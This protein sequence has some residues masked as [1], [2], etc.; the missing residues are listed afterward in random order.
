MLSGRSHRPNKTSDEALAELELQ[1]GQQFDPEVIEVLMRVVL[2]KDLTLSA[3]Q[4][5]RVLVA[6]SDVEFLNLLKLRLLNAGFEVQTLTNV[7]EVA[8]QLLDDPPSV[9]LAG[10]SS[11]DERAFDLL[12][13]LRG[14]D[15]LRHVPIAFIGDNPDRILRVRAMRHGVDDFLTK[16]DDLEEVVSRVE[17]ILIREASRRTPRASQR[18][19][20]ITGQLDT[21]PLPDIIQMLNMGMK[22]ALVSIYSDDQAGQIWF[23]EGAAVHAEA[24]DSRGAEAIYQMLRW[25]GGDFAIEHG[26]VTGGSTIETDTMFLVMEGLRLLDESAAAGGAPAA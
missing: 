9:V 1:A 15:T 26:V 23:S 19:R 14:D 11:G 17:N 10:V 21:L 3:D 4:K 25:S 7:D 20:G 6:D 24:G 12:T 13:A 8:V 22:T 5:P 18:R 16:S 2:E